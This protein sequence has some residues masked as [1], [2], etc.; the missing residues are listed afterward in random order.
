MMISAAPRTLQQLS[1]WIFVPIVLV[2]LLLLRVGLE[3]AYADRIYP[4][5]QV[6]GVDLGGQTVSEAATHLQEQIDAYGNRTIPIQ[7]G[8]QST[9][10]T[11][12][13]LGFK[14]DA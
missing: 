10:V 14:P 3:V 9:T 11:A 2:G 8:D 7:V 12:R 13:E 4:G 1:Y 5:V 6:M